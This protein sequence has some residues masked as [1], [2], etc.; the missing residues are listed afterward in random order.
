MTIANLV[1]MIANITAKELN[2][3]RE[4]IERPYVS[5]E[6][7]SEARAI[8]AKVAFAY[9]AP[10]SAIRRVLKRNENLT[11]YYLAHS[12]REELIYEVKKQIEFYLNQLEGNEE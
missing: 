5:T 9:G 1:N 6:N 4:D 8:I 7:A 11:M 2:V 12:A 3:T 10:I